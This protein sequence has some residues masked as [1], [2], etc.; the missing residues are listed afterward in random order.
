MDMTSFGVGSGTIA[1]ISFVIALL[2]KLNHKRFK[3]SCCGKKMEITID[4]EST[5]PPRKESI[6]IT[7]PETFSRKGSLHIVVPTEVK[8]VVENESAKV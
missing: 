4:V 7:V 5:T 1:I 8:V 6:A 3:S 2:V